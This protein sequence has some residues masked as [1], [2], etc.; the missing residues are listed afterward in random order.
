MRAI[1]T[2]T[3]LLLTLSLC[4]G[5][6][7]AQE[8]APPEKPAPEAPAPRRAPEGS[9]IIALPS[10]DVNPAGSLQLLFTH[11]FTEKVAG[12]NIHSLFSFDAGAEIGIGLSYAPVPNLEV[13]LLRNR[14][15]EDYELSAKYRLFSAAG[16]AF[17]AALRV[18]ANWRTQSTKDACRET[19]RPDSCSVSDHKNGVFA[20]AIA[21]VNIFS[22]VRVTIVPTYVS[23]A[24][25]QNS[26]HRDI[27]NVPVA[28]SIAV[29]RSINVQGEVVPQSGIGGSPATGWIAS[30]EKTVLRHR[31]AFTIGNI[32]PTTVDQYI[33]PDFLGR[34]G[35]YYF[36]F[37]IVRLWKLK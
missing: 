32:R 25:Q 26:I 13:G 28:V 37:N 19:E 24:V 16:G 30:V 33:A 5:A 27:F 18:G 6:I 22:R 4:A 17:A 12:S 23:Y 3:S 1:R 2:R 8:A 31:F 7:G 20:Q 15:L 9:V 10:A 34:P 21:G 11:R 29:T 14:V 36:G 35:D